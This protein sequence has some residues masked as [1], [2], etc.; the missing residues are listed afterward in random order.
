VPARATVGVAG[1]PKGAK[2]EVECIALAG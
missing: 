1:L 2:V